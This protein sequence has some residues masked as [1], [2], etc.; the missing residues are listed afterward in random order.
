MPSDAASWTLTGLI[1]VRN[2]GLL[3]TGAV[4]DFLLVWEDLVKGRSRRAFGFSPLGTLSRVGNLLNAE[5]ETLAHL[6][7]R[8]EAGTS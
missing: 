7:S 2:W 8:A 4:P 3:E 1:Q 5:G 6:A